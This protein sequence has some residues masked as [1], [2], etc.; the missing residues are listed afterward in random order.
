MILA[1]KNQVTKMVQANETVPKA[2]QNNVVI[3]KV[4]GGM[5]FCLKP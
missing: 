3:G 4:G 1:K 2:N 5:S